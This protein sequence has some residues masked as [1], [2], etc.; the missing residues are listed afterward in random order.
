M[1]FSSATSLAQSST[2]NA[3]HTT[4]AAS[5]VE[6]LAEDGGVVDQ[7]PE[8]TNNP[9]HSSSTPSPSPSLSSSAAVVVAP[10]PSALPRGPKTVY[11]V[12]HAESAYNAYKLSPLNWLTLKA[13]KDPMIFDPPLSPLG[14]TQLT[15]LSAISAKHR[16]THKA[17]LLVVSPLKRAID[18][19]LAVMGS[20]IQPQ[21]QP[22]AYPLPVYVSALCTEVLDTSADIGSPPSALSAAYPLLSFSHLPAAWWYHADPSQPRAITDEPKERVSRRVSEF[23]HWLCQRDEQCI[24]VVS[25]SS[26]IRHCTGARLKIDNCQVQQC[27]VRQ[28]SDGRIQVSV[29]RDRVD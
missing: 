18:T 7:L 24:I 28:H 23:M 25:H 15:A 11:F 3:T 12:R 29:Q 14:L 16:L 10:S 20:G 5:N 21:Q 13:L 1:E 27:E 22:A 17:Q 8:S 4:A 2:G 9:A 19:A 26:F 6:Q